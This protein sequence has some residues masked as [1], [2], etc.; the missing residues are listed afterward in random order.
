[1]NQPSSTI[2]AAGIAGITA[3]TLLLIVK[4]AWPD[5][6]VQIPASYQGYLITAI[7]VGIGYCKKEN[8]LPLKTP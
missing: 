8:V 4:I 3:S 2:T 6:Y 5:V 7:M 1:M